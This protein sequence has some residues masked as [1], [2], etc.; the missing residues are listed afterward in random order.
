M[1]DTIRYLPKQ[2]FY[3][4]PWLMQWNRLLGRRGETFENEGD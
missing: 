3:L 2:S 1:E 4:C